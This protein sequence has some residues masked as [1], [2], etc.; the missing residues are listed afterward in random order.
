M[1]KRTFEL[2]DE[3]RRA[4]SKMCGDL[5]LWM[6]EGRD[7]GYMSNK[8]NLAPS[9]VESNIDELLYVLRRQVGI[10]RFLKTLFRRK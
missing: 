2:T 5:T 3:E 6:L 1:F 7:I 10:K 4:V 9:Q 8:L